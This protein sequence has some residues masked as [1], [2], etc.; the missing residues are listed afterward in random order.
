MYFFFTGHITA[1]LYK[2]IE[3][4]RR[5]TCIKFVP[6]SGHKNYI[7]FANDKG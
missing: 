3:T 7:Y 2:V 1:N 6:Y 5:E 4:F